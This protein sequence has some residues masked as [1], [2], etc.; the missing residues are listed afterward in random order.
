MSNSVLLSTKKVLGI[1]ADY[2]AF[3]QDII[4]H[5]NTA[6]MAVSQLGVGTSNDMEIFD[7]TTLW[8]DL[9]GNFTAY[10][11]VKT[12]VYLRVRLLFD[13]PTTSFL[14]K[15][16]EEQLREY[17]WRISVAREYE[18]AGATDLPGELVIDGGSP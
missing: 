18:L 6:L 10:N 5:I 2:T 13:P 9:L 7:E 14:L 12:Y 4:M 1:D 15:A 16:Q 11:A 3:D 8:S 17:E